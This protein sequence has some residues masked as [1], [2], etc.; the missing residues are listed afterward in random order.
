MPLDSLPNINILSRHTVDR[1]LVY[2]ETGTSVI[3]GPIIKSML[4]G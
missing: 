3:K 2:N 1:N 4:L